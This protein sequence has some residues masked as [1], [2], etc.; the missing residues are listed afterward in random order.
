[1]GGVGWGKFSRE[2]RWRNWKYVLDTKK[3]V[4]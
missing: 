2:W 3:T 4:I 1:M